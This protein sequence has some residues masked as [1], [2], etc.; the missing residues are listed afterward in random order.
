[1]MID[2]TGEYLAALCDTTERMLRPLLDAGATQRSMVLAAPALARVQ[3]HNGGNLFEPDAE[4]PMQGFILPV[5]VEYPDTP[6][7]TDPRAAI[8]EGEIVDLV[9]FTPG[10][11]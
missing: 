2:L 10:L 5:R 6:E 7:T 9:A 4:S 3:V 8:T 11:R 1:M